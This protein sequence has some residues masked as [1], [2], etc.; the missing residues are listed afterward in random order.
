MFLTFNRVLAKNSQNDFLLFWISFTKFFLIFENTF[1]KIVK[2]TCF[3]CFEKLK[4]ENGPK[5]T[6][7]IGP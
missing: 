5:M 1:L 2:G 6:K 3:E 7:E 4:I